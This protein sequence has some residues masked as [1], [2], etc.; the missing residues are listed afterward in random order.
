MYNIEYIILLPMINIEC[1]LSGCNL[2]AICKCIR[3]RAD[4]YNATI[5][6]HVTRNRVEELPLLESKSRSFKL[7][8]DVRRSRMISRERDGTK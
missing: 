8:D 6:P 7:N 1:I 3:I 5:V 2:L 4:E